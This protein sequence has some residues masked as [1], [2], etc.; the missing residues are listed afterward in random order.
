MSE[1]KDSKTHG[2]D[3]YHHFDDSTD[4]AG[5]LKSVYADWADAYD[6]DNDNKLGTVSQPTTVAML[7]RHLENK[8]A[9]IMDVG[10]MMRLSLRTRV[11]T[12]H[13]SPIPIFCSGPVVRC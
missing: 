8:D 10:W 13:L 4:Q 7:T 9:Q 3:K 11:S 2:I 6:D 1:P 12:L 5:Q